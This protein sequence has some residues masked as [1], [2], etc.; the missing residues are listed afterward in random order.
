[1]HDRWTYGLTHRM[2]QCMQRLA[3][4]D[5]LAADSMANRAI[6]PAMGLFV[7]LICSIYPMYLSIFASV[8]LSTGL[9]ILP[10]YLV[11]LSN[12]PIHLYLVSVSSQP[13][14]LSSQP[15]FLSFYLSVVYLSIHLPIH[16]SIYLSIYPSVHLSIFLS[17][18]CPSI[19]LSTYLFL[20]Y[21]SIYLSLFLSIFLS[22]HPSIRLSVCLPVCL[23][24]GYVS[25]CLSLRPFFLSLSLSSKEAW[26]STSRVTDLWNP[27]K[28]QT[29]KGSQQRDFTAKRSPSKQISQQRDLIAEKSHRKESHSKEV[30]QQ[31]SP[32]AKR[33][34]SND[35]S[36]QR[37]LTAKKS[38]RRKSRTKTLVSGLYGTSR[39]KASF[40]HHP[41]S[42]FEGSLARNASFKVSGC[43]KR[44]ALQDKT[45]LG[46]WMG[47]VC[48][49]T[50]AEHV[51]L[52][53]DHARG[54][55]ARKLRFHIFNF[56]FMKEVSHESFDFTSSTFFLGKPRTKA[57]LS[58]LQL[59][60]WWDPL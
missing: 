35:I 55:L 9:S 28:S 20:T 30:S 27:V 41:F 48:R 22:F 18:F 45:C 32:I 52:G 14:H 11:N 13:T 40:S 59:S 36:Q 46:R 54:G 1:M 21:L 19:S 51:R 5:L 8:Y 4:A 37:D 60:A 57:M 38:H 6:C 29:K 34:H 7:R 49:A 58:H 24:C 53:A 26:K 39:K 47:K 42:L 50:V 3:E 17:F 25:M 33:S 2:F 23:S 31:R 16:P 43:T 12:Q 10:I 44:S 56:H 15:I